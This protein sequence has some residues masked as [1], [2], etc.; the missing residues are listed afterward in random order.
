MAL[1]HCDSPS[2]HHRSCAQAR[3]CTRFSTPQPAT[4]WFSWGDL[5]YLEWRPPQYVNSV[6]VIC[7]VE[8]RIQVILIV[9]S[10][11][12]NKYFFLVS[13][14]SINSNL[15]V[16]HAVVI[17]WIYFTVTFPIGTSTVSLNTFLLVLVMESNCHDAVAN[18]NVWQRNEVQQFT[19][20]RCTCKRKKLEIQIVVWNHF[21][22]WDDIQAK[23]VH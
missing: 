7:T 13:T 5:L 12:T 22:P 3:V 16:T 19:R 4:V 10:F 11:L 15:V 6:F 17:W 21:T 18:V 20:K 1:Q 14:L 23:W 2:A 9:T 8:G